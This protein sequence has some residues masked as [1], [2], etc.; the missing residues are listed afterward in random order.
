MVESEKL[1]G[2]FVALAAADLE[3]HKAA[4]DR[5]AANQE[6]QQS[7]LVEFADM[8]NAHSK[9][10]EDIQRVWTKNFA[11]Q[12]ALLNQQTKVLEAMRALA[13]P[14]ERVN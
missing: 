10:L 8:L 9:L 2:K 14:D 1:I 5:L 4:L 6:A 12:G 13:L 3:S 7:Q 11:E